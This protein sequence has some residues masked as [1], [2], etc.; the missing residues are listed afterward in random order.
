PRVSYDAFRDGWLRSGSGYVCFTRYPCKRKEQS[1][2]RL[3][4]IL[5][6][7]VVATAFA[8]AQTSSSGSSTSSS[9]TQGSS[10]QQSSPQQSSPS[11]SSS[12][13]SSMGSTSSQGS[14]DQPA[15]QGSQDQSGTGSA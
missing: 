7:L 1:M 10:A 2:K 5:A 13:N 3:L 14:Q 9:G 6:V 12:G 15:S 11:S 8:M 4:E